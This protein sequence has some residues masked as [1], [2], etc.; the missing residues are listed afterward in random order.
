MMSI[1]VLSSVLPDTDN[2]K[3]SSSWYFL[4]Y[5]TS[6]GPKQDCKNV[7]HSFE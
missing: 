1:P 3:R 2:C 7:G 5:V 6:L 4:I